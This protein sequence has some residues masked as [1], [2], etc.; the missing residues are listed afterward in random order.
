MKNIQIFTDKTAIGLSVLCAVHCLAFPL[1]VVVLPSV[2]AMQFDNE[3]FHIWMLVIVIPT[4]LYALI[5]GCKRHSRYGLLAFG[6]IGLSC[7]IMALTLSEAI[8][9]EWGEKILTL[10]GAILLVIGHYRNYRLCLAHD[11]QCACDS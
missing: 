7:L 8:L 1:L 4:S 5:F 11:A 9:G 6:V 2:G 10:F 3:A